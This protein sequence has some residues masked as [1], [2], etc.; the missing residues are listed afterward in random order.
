MNPKPFS[1]AYL[2]EQDGHQVYFAQY[3]NVSG[4]PILVCHGGPGGK[5]KPKNIS[6]YDLSRYHVITFDQRG[7]GQSLPLG[8]IEH[9]TTQTSI[10]DMERLRQT[11]QIKQWYVDGGSW[12]S[13]LALVYAETFPSAVSGLLLRSIFLAREQDEA[14]AF[15]QDTGIV[16][17]FPDLWEKR[18]QFLNQYQTAP[19]SAAKE[20][21]AQLDSAKPDAV[22]E[23]VAGVMNWEGNLLSAQTDLTFTDPADVTPENIASVRVFLHY[24]AHDF[25]LKPNQIVKNLITIKH[26]PVIIVHGRYDLLCPAD[27]A[28][29]LSK[30][31]TKAEVIILPTS[32]HRL[33][34][35]GEVAKK[36]AFNYFLNQF[37]NPK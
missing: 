11:L 36:Y 9:N 33:T 21:L 15:S 13:T 30:H 7:C 10:Q 8:K 23:I 19:A 14:W 32:N 4:D 27:Q 17:V 34:A 18:L 20:L 37:S 12:G 1:T 28:W 6:S 2:P 29:E 24:E 31:L 26:L 22:N 16:K 35:D 3:G 25:F 5:S